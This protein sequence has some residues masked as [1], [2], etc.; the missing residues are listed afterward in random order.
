MIYWSLITQRIG[1]GERSGCCNQERSPLLNELRRLGRNRCTSRPHTRHT[2][3]FSTVSLLPFWLRFQTSP[4]F[5][6]HHFWLS[7][8]AFC[9]PKLSVPIICSKVKSAKETCKDTVSTVPLSAPNSGISW[10]QLTW[11]LPCFSS[12]GFVLPVSETASLLRSA[13]GF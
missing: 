12:V 4:H 9:I 13:P 11:T 7:A 8:I 6:P 5:T 1:I 3:S 10:I 2:T